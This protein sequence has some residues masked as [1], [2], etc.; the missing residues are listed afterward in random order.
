MPKHKY[1]KGQIVFVVLFH[2]LEIVKSIY[3]EARKHMK[4][5]Y[6]VWAEDGRLLC[7]YGC[8]V[9]T[10]EEKAKEV[11]EQYARAGYELKETAPNL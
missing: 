1:T 10:S 4:R 5:Q 8:Q 11:F 2:P 3:D 7:V 9:F 6:W